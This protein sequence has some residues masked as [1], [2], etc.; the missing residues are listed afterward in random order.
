MAFWGGLTYSW[1]KKIKSNGEKEQYTHLNTELQRLAR[2]D[3]K[4]FQSEQ[5]KEIEEN[6]KMVKTRDIFKKIRDNKGTIIQR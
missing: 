4:A 1:E 3:K 6:N 2:R 5:C